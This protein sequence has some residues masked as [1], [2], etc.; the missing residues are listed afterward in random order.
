MSDPFTGEIQMFAF[1]FAP[2]GWAFCHGQ[3]LP[4]AQ[5]PELA[6][7]LGKTFGGDAFINFGLPDLRGKVP[8]G[9][10][11]GHPIGSSV[12]S[13]QVTLRGDQMPS[14]SHV[15]D[16]YAQKVAA[17]KYAVPT[18]NSAVTVPGSV[19]PFSSAAPSAAFHPSAVDVTGKGQPHENQQPYLAM[20]FCIALDGLIPRFD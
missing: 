9:T 5:N 19:Q 20:N 8:G 13:A 3:L 2:F 12:G 1:P 7:V 10:T 16:V 14:H 18:G 11:D 4:V 17:S 6:A 15:F